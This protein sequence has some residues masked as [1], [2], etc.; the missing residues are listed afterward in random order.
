MQRLGRLPDESTAIAEHATNVRV[1]FVAEFAARLHDPRRFGIRNLADRF[2]KRLVP[3]RGASTPWN[4]HREEPDEIAVTSGSGPN[5]AAQAG[6]LVGLRHDER[7]DMVTGDE[8]VRDQEEGDLVAHGGD[9]EV[10]SGAAE[11]TTFRVRL[12]RVSHAPS[13]A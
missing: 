9:I 3:S 2:D 1:G 6:V 4:Y 8:V 5:R 13:H 7:F 12:P 10:Q 11:G